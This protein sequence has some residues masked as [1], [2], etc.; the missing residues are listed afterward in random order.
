MF[1][2][3]SRIYK[4]Y[5]QNSGFHVVVQHVVQRDSRQA[6]RTKHKINVSNQIFLFTNSK[7][8]W[9]ETSILHSIQSARREPRQTTCR[10]TTWNPLYPQRTQ[11][12]P[13]STNKTVN[14]CRKHGDEMAPNN[15]VNWDQKERRAQ[16]LP[17]FNS[18]T[19]LRLFHLL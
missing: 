8:I 11:Q 19:W 15:R 1:A 17:R 16:P 4:I 18:I 10:T 12:S 2:F 5:K 3:S 9:F 7:N 14:T 13:L 6:N